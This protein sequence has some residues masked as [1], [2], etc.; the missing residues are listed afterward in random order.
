LDERIVPKDPP[1]S[2]NI[3]SSTHREKQGVFS[4]YWKKSFNNFVWMSSANTNGKKREMKLF[5]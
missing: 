4:A 1:F 5:E 3:P 2:R